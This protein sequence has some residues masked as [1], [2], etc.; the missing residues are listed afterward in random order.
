MG[1]KN[2]LLITS[3]A[4]QVGEKQEFVYS[5]FGKMNG[6]KVKGKGRRMDTKQNKKLYYLVG[7][8]GVLVGLLGVT[9][10]KRGF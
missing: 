8:F 9:I 5:I 7:L 10:V 6:K 3:S 4:K 1:K 2:E